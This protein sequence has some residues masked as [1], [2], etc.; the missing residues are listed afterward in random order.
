M[1]KQTPQYIYWIIA[2]L[3]ACGC[4]MLGFEQTS[5]EEALING[6][7]GG[8]L[9]VGQP[10]KVSVRVWLSANEKLVSNSLILEEDQKRVTVSATK[11]RTLRMGQDNASEPTIETMQVDFTPAATGSYLFLAPSTGATQ[12][13]EVN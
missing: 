2:I 11:L 4:A 3:L 1:I 10:A 6:F 12:N 9:E 5:R 7:T 8:P 13:I